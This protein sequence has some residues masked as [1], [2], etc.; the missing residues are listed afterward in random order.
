MQEIYSRLSKEERSILCTYNDRG[1]SYTV[2]E[3]ESK[4][5]TEQES[6]NQTFDEV[7]Q[8]QPLKVLQTK[9]FN[10]SSKPLKAAKPAPQQSSKTR[11]STGTPIKPKTLPKSR[12]NSS[13]SSVKSQNTSKSS[14]KSS[15]SRKCRRYSK[16]SNSVKIFD[17]CKVPNWK[18]EVSKLIRTVYRHQL[19]CGKLRDE[20]NKI[21]GSKILIEY[22]KV[23]NS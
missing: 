14:C 9:I 6:I 7:H 2:K 1:T 18:Y 10:S 23:N 12:R 21:G 4:L 20:L 13:K 17:L 8:H 3:S 19:L 11:C 22:K 16:P 15:F 5:K